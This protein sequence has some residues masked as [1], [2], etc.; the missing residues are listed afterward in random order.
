M[1]P[2]SFCVCMYVCVC[3]WRE[4]AM[5]IAVCGDSVERTEQ[6]ASNLRACSSVMRAVAQKEPSNFPKI[7]LICKTQSST[8]T[9]PASAAEWA[10][11][12]V[13]INACWAKPKCMV[14]M[15]ACSPA[16]YPF[17][18]HFCR[19]VNVNGARIVGSTTAPTSDAKGAAMRTK[20]SNQIIH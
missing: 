10:A 12:V 9:L 2:G 16:H 15:G 14:I 17:G 6:N 20:R 4:T 8:T 5:M 11:A 18:F 19:S 13:E 7:Y 1:Q 3:M